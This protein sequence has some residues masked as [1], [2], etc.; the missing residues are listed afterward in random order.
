MWVRGA[1]IQCFRETPEVSR[2][3]KNQEGKTIRQ[4]NSVNYNYQLDKI[5]ILKAV[6]ETKKKKRISETLR[7]IMAKIFIMFIAGF[8][9][10][11]RAIHI[12][13]P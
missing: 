8:V 13:C 11:H 9:F 6:S 4:N 3:R 1:E 10:S 2:S 7:D 5:S 12:S